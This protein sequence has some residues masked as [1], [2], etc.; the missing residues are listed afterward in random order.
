MTVNTPI[1]GLGNSQTN[2]GDRPKVTTGQ[3]SG[4]TAGTTA[5]HTDGTFTGGI[6]TTAYTIGDLVRFLKVNGIIPL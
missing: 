3:T 4:Y 1:P 5:A 6:G 2:P